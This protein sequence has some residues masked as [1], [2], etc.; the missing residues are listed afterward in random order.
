MNHSSLASGD[1]LV[2]ASWHCT[3]HLLLKWRNPSLQL[4]AKEREG[5]RDGKAP[6]AWHGNAGVKAGM[7]DSLA[8]TRLPFPWLCG[9]CAAPNPIPLA[10]MHPR[11]LSCPLGI[12]VSLEG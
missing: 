2:C 9:L 12:G 3:I 4:A 5:R 6:D 11:Q 10:Q 7:L 1:G 8:M